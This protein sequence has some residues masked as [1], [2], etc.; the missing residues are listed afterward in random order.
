VA[1][2]N[3]DPAVAGI[4]QLEGDIPRSELPEKSLPA[5]VAYQIIHDE[6]PSTATRG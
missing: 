5:D 3:L 2:R 4:F 6:L 1:P